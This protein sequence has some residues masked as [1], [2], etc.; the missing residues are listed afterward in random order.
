[1]SLRGCNQQNRE[2]EKFHRT[3][4]LI[5]SIKKTGQVEK[6]EEKRNYYKL[7]EI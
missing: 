6:K 5:A 1:M 2:Y 3:N 7:K 4:G